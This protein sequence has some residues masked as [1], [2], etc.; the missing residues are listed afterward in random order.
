[1]AVSSLLLQGFGLL[2]SIVINF[3]GGSG[4]AGGYRLVIA[5]YAFFVLIPSS[6]LSVA[7]VRMVSGCCAE[8]RSDKAI[9][10]SD[11]LILA[12]TL[13]ACLLSGVMF[14]FADKLSLLIPEIEE[15]PASLKILSFSLPFSAV[16]A[17]IR[18]YFIAIRR[19]LIPCIA[20][21]AE[22]AAEVLLCVVFLKGC[23]ISPVIS[24]CLSSSLAAVPSS[25]ISLFCYFLTRKPEK[26]GREKL[27]VPL[28]QVLSII[29]PCTASAALRSGL[30]AAENLLIPLGLMRYGSDPRGAMADYGLICAMAMPLV[31]FPSFAVLP[32][33]SLIVTEISA[34]KT[35]GR[36]NGIRHMTER[37]TSMTLEYAIPITIFLAVFSGEIGLCLFRSREAGKYIAALAPV[38]PLMYLDSAADGIL[39]GLDKQTSY[40]LFNLA[41]S[42]LR[43]ALTVIL[44]PVAGPWGIVAVILFSELFNTTL[45]YLK[46]VSTAEIKTD[47]LRNI[48]VPLISALLS[49]A[50]VSRSIQEGGLI[51]LCLKGIITAAGYIS[52]LLFMERIMQ[53]SRKKHS[54]DKRHIG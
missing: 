32:F 26:S 11:R 20:Q 9:F 17:V 37:L 29:L 25:V 50:A 24:A 51:L 53:I 43:V 23:N 18:G 38:C 12:G 33:S 52:I 3:S 16:T 34:A 39:K 35:L 47:I 54:G 19:P 21:I 31:I 28:K 13:T 10:I 48:L 14:F 41:D 46:L 36:K 22:G 4:A 8:S 45:S 1:M 6:G 2:I 27:R 7:A 49:C 30:S 40:F 42:L 5:L 44:L 15:A